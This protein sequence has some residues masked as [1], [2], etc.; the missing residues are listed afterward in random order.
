ML[1]SNLGNLGVTYKAHPKRVTIANN[2]VSDITERS[3]TV[4]QGTYIIVAQSSAE[5]NQTVYSS[6]GTI[7]AAGVGKTVVTI[8]TLTSDTYHIVGNNFT[9]VAVTTSNDALYFGLTLI[10]LK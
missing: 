6:T 10:Q 9:G 8:A 4:P 1:N 7:I 5:L 3:E 2:G